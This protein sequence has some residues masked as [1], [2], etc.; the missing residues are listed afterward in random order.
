MIV[1]HTILPPVIPKELELRIK[2]SG[3]RVDFKDLQFLQGG[4]IF[5]NQTVE[6]VEN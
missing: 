6:F 3:S 5:Q 2:L 1:A 4:L